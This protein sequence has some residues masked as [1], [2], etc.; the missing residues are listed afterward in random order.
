MV[1]IEIPLPYC[2]VNVITICIQSNQ[3]SLNYQS[4]CVTVYD[5]YK[6]K[7]HDQLMINSQIDFK[8]YNKLQTY[9]N[10]TIIHT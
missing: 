7:F 1:I 9:L 5:N 10:K 2:I 8:N 4:V 6:Y 3:N